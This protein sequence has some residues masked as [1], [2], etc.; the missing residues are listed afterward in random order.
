MWCMTK[1]LSLSL[2]SEDEAMLARL[3]GENS[4]ERRVLISW[5]RLRGMSPDQIRSEASLIRVLLRIGAERLREQALDEGYAQLAA[6]RDAIEEAESHEARA[7][8]VHRTEA[9]S[10]G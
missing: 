2:E 1:R 4:P 6:E 7:R 9:T 5:T 10:A 3:A 8:Y